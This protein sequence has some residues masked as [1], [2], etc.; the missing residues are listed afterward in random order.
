MKSDRMLALC[1]VPR[2]QP[3]AQALLALPVGAFTWKTVSKAWGN[4]S[5]VLR[6]VCVSSKL[7]LPP[8]S[9]MPS[10]EKMM[11]K[12]KSRRSKD[13]M[14]FMEFNKEATRLLSEAQCLEDKAELDVG[15]RQFGRQPSR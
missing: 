3:Q 14:D 11:I 13:A 2:C 1:K 10:K 6:L 7:N 4:V 15:Q 5:K 9:C 8:K 12:R